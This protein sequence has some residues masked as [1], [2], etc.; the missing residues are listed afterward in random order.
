LPTTDKKD[1]PSWRL[2]RLH[3]LVLIAAIF[4]AFLKRK[5]LLLLMRAAWK[6]L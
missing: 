4:A 1:H 6:R 5:P 2:A 3:Q